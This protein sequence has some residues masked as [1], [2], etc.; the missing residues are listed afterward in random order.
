[1]A[2]EPDTAEPFRQAIL[3]TLR[4]L[5][6]TACVQ[7]VCQV[8]LRTRDRTLED[9]ILAQGWLPEEPIELRIQVALK[10]GKVDV[11]ERAGD[12]AL[13]ALVLAVRDSD[14]AISSS[15]KTPLRKVLENVT[16]AVSAVEPLLEAARNADSTIAERATARLV[17][18]RDPDT[19]DE[20]CARWAERRDPVSTKAILTGGYVAQ[21]PI[22]VRILT[23]LKVGQ[24]QLVIHAGYEILGP[25]LA[26]FEDSDTT[27]AQLARTAV[28]LLGIQ[29]LTEWLEHSDAHVRRAACQAL[30][31]LGDVC[32]VKPLIERLEDSNSSVRQA[33]CAALGELGE[34]CLAEALVV[35][36]Q[37]KAKAVEKFRQLVQ[38]GDSRP[39]DLLIERLESQDWQSRHAA[40]ETLGQL[41]DARAV[42]SLIGRLAD[43]GS[44]RYGEGRTVARAACV[45]LGRLGDAQAVEPLIERLDASD[46]R[47]RQAACEA[48]GLLGDARAAPPLIGRLTDTGGGQY[49]HERAVARA[50]CAALGRLGDIRGVEPL[51]ERLD[52]SDSGVHQ[53]ALE[54]LEQLGEGRFANAFLG[55]LRGKAEAIEESRRLVQEGD[56]RPLDLMIVRLESAEWTTRRAACE[57]LGQLG[58]ARAVQ[59]L[60]GRLADTGGERYSDR[61]AVAQA[62][63]VALGRLGDARAVEPLIER[64]DDSDSDVRREACDAL[65]QLGDARAVEPLVERLE[66]E[67]WSVRETACQTL[68]RLGDARAVPPLIGRLIDTGG[69][70]YRNERAVARAACSA[71]GQLGDIRGVGPL[72][73]RLD[74]SDSGVRQAALEALEQLGEGRMAK[75]YLGLLQGNAK[76]IE[77]SQRL[78]QEGDPRPVDLMIA[79]LQSAE[80]NV[81]C[82][83]CETLGQLGDAR[84]VQSLIG[85]LADTGGERYGIRRSRLRPQHTASRK[86]G[87]YTGS[88]ATDRAVERYGDRRAVAQAA[89]VALGRLGDAQAV[90]PLI[91]RLEDFD[92]DICRA[93]CEALGLLGDPSAVQ[94]LVERLAATGGSSY[95]GIAPRICESLRQL[96]QQPFAEAMLS[97]VKGKTD[98]AKLLA[99]LASAGDLRAM[100]TLAEWSNCG[101]WGARWRPAC[102]GLNSMYRVLKG[103]HKELFCRRCLT[104]FEKSV[105]KTLENRTGR[106]FC[107][108]VCRKAA[109]AWFGIRTVVCV[110][111]SGREDT[112]PPSLDESGGVLRV[113]WRPPA[114]LFDFDSVEIVRASDYD[115]EHFCVSVGNDTDLF[116]KRRY[117]R[118]PCTV[119]SECELSENTMR[120]L[121]DFLGEVSVA[122]ITE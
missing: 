76:A 113:H 35:F 106:F 75:A 8:W 39:V 47:V 110:I 13:A 24:P 40:C 60:I 34:G 79:R 98:N 64:L 2:G 27:I 70:R 25:L 121:A 18:L 97:T 1:M 54:A 29:P 93:A 59:S 112:P 32:A 30:S 71:L 50:A 46:E 42:Q 5:E 104:R 48:L 119:A 67:D 89:C 23:A 109:H 100:D 92:A 61:R 102:D 115:V 55:L 49:P 107:C 99:E 86:I 14:R 80:W 103:S 72:I 31:R 22:E 16:E 122:P 52:D 118:L 120:V 33:A 57:T 26:A 3:D 66:D 114:S 94:P 117:K 38:A 78:V 68:G 21:R 116:R 74:D 10:S 95:G 4:S 51:I 108:R 96:G 81:R 36:L 105:V 73:E 9:L 17:S 69:E 53:A 83:A 84:A 41:G 28:R 87:R 37:G 88:R 44:E 56:S 58:D 101:D 12:E 62:A 82:A 65:G 45:A 20:L 111:H 63:C 43:T 11:V 15:A 90:Q 6:A 7:A 91:Q 19:I 77:E 85:R